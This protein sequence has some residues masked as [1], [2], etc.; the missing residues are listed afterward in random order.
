MGILNECESVGRQEFP[1]A[2]YQ[3]AKALKAFGEGILA[4]FKE[5]KMKWSFEEGFGF[6]D[7]KSGK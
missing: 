4:L 2:D 1:T 6:L 7:K 5:E 3:D